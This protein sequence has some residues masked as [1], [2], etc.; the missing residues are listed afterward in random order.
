[1]FSFWMFAYI[2]VIGAIPIA[3]GMIPAPD[4]N[5]ASTVAGF[6]R[7]YANHRWWLALVW[8]ILLTV[9]PLGVTAL[10][11]YRYPDIQAQATLD[12]DEGF[13]DGFRWIRNPKS[14]AGRIPWIVPK[15]LSSGLMWAGYTVA[16]S[17]SDDKISAFALLIY[18]ADQGI[19]HYIWYGGKGNPHYGEGHIPM[20]LYDHG[21]DNIRGIQVLYHATDRASAALN[22]FYRPLEIFY[23]KEKGTIEI[24]DS[25][26][27]RN[28]L[29]N[30][31]DDSFTF[32]PYPMAD[33]PYVKQPGLQISEISSATPDLKLIFRVQDVYEQP[34]SGVKVFLSTEFGYSYNQILPNDASDAIIA[35]PSYLPHAQVEISRSGYHTLSADVA[36][37][38]NIQRVEAVL[39]PQRRR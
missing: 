33:R 8:Y 28:V 4:A 9:T 35:L 39:E 31:D 5:D 38:Q 10:R 15:G 17:R 16:V 3:I 1:M 2:A 19:G 37:N 20:A 12:R 30:L 21:R 34:M 22:G 18:G 7:W 24:Y 25:E 26:S 6:A 11:N 23:N 13:S 27:G 32:G 36:L 14:G 29:F